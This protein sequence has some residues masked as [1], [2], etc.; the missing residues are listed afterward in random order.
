MRKID[1]W[2][3]V[4]N[5]SIAICGLVLIAKMFFRKYLEQFILPILVIGGIALLLFMVSEFMKL[6]IKGD[7]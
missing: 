5:F 4:S 7:K 6:I 3:R 1:F 2:K